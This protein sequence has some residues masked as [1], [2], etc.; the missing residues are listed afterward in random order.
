MTEDSLLSQS[1]YRRFHSTETEVTKVYNDLLLA[2]DK[3]QMSALCLLDLTAA[4]DTVDHGLLL[5]RLARQFGL[6]GVV[7]TRRICLTDVFG[8]TMV[9]ICLCMEIF[10]L[11][12]TGVIP[13]ST[14]IR[15]LHCGTGRQDTSAR[16]EVPR[17]R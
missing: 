11:G 6:R 13:W 15:A 17:I 1:A 10:M 16:C 5:H 12:A 8:F 4:F 2:A 7:L 3:G 14:I 9:V